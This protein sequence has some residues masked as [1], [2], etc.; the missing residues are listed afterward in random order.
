MAKRQ[1]DACALFCYNKA[2]VNA[3]KK[4]MLADTE[5]IKL[6]DIFKVLGDATRAKI[7]LAL[8]KDELCVCDIAH[9]LGLSISAVSHQLRMLRNLG[10]V[11]YRNEGRMVFYTLDNEHIMH[12]IEEGIKH[13]SK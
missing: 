3:L 8:S 1:K 11:K 10:L 5:L 6:V 9:V 13:I 2:K 4:T 7:L 12:L